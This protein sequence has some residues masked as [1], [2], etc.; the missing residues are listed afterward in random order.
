MN[1]AELLKEA[2]MLLCTRLV[3]SPTYDGNRKALGDKIESYLVNKCD[4]IAAIEAER[5][6]QINKHG[7][8]LN[9]DVEH[10]TGGSLKMA[11]VALLTEN[12][13]EFPADW[14]DEICQHMINKSEEERLEIAGSLIA[15]EIARRKYITATAEDHE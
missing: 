12:E 5:M 10:N 2:Y 4:G 3:K 13:G 7:R 15:A 9:Y 1:A 8:T 11:A 6:E 14:T